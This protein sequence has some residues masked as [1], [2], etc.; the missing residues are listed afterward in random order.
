MVEDF[1]QDDFDM[2]DPSAKRVLV[3]LSQFEKGL[4]VTVD[5]LH[6]KTGLMP[7][8][9]ND[10]VRHLTKSKLVD[11]PEP[12]KKHGPYEFNTVEIT[13]FGREVLAKFG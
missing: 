4:I 7:E 11:N 6:R 9:L 1:E 10:A 13:D 3:V 2:I 8:A 5:L 12:E